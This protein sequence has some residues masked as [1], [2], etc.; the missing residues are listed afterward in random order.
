MLAPTSHRHVVRRLALDL[1]CR[2]ETVGVFADLEMSRLVKSTGLSSQ[3]RAFLRELVY[4]VLRWQARLDWLLGHCSNRRLETLTPPIRNLLRLGA[5]QLCMM[6][7]IPSYA[8]VSETVQLAKQVGHAGV[9]AFINAVLRA[10]E[11]QRQAILLPEQETDLMG[12][13]TITEA[14]PRWL[15]DRWLQREGAA[16][17]VMMCQ[18]N[19]R[20]PSLVVRTNRLRATRQRL[21]ESLA[22][23]GCQVEPC[24]FAPDGIR[25]ISHP[26]LEQLRSYTQGWFT[27][28]DEAAMLCGYLLDPQPGERVLDACAAPGGKASQAA[29]LMGDSGEVMCLDQSHRRLLRAA[30][31]YHRLGLQSLRLVAADATTVGFRCA[32]DCILVDAPC[33]GLGVL[34]RHPEAKWRKGPELISSMVTLQQAILHYVSRFLRPGGSLVYTTCSTEPEEN[35]QVVQAFLDTH[36]DY[37][38]DAATAYLPAAAHRFAESGTWFQTWP[39]PQGMDGFFGARLRRLI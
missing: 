1:L 33:S 29:E 22:S 6:D 2:I 28:Q 38:L 24:H 31:N 11:R 27:V 14:H 4:G 25:L 19:N 26:P 17:T 8:A 3:A 30:R 5:Y 13:L 7:H 34:R 36:R 15:I 20:V 32:F 10:L 37:Q 23:Q 39:G 18:A 21:I 35:Q 9:V 16:R 12:Y